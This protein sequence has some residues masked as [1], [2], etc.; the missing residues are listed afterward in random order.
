MRMAPI[1][2]ASRTS[3][4]SWTTRIEHPLATIQVTP[5]SEGQLSGAGVR[6]RYRQLSKIQVS[7]VQTVSWQLQLSPR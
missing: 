4:Y 2:S 6:R 3:Q 7:Q 1:I 5:D